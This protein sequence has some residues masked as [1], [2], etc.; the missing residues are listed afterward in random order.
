MQYLALIA[1]LGLRPRACKRARYCKQAPNLPQV[2]H[3]GKKTKTKSQMRGVTF[4]CV[5]I[6]SGLSTLQLCTFPRLTAAK[7]PG[8]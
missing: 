3:K 7:I 4:H 6:I 2:I 1:S 5:K 8:K